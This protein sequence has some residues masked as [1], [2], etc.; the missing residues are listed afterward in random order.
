MTETMELQTP[1]SNDE[2]AESLYVNGVRMGFVRRGK[3]S[4][5]PIL[6]LLHGFTGSAN[7]WSSLLDALAKMGIQVIA[8][9]MLG[10][11]QS[12]A[13][14]DPQRYAIEHCQVDILAALQQLGVAPQQAILLGYSMGGRVALYTALS[15]YFR[16]LILESASPGLLD[17]VERAQRQ[18]SDNVLA[19]RIEYEGIP[20]FIDYWQ[21]IPLFASQ[22]NM[23]HDRFAAQREQRL[24]NNPL[25]LANSL[26]G[27]GTGVQPALDGRLQELTLPVLLI[28]GALDSK[29]CTIAHQM[30]RQIPNSRLAIV[31]D[32]GHAVHLEQPE[33][34]VVLLRAFYESITSP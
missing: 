4:D 27:L 26:R 17:P 3:P 33:R 9:D 13:P 12:S 29:F 34:F 1:L 32:A 22:Q 28:A 19:D 24:N 11:G 30:A 25:G 20:A 16:A 31:P 21:S 5:A 10:H 18:Q 8:L 2:M 6:V 15:G 7:S 23:P 14:V